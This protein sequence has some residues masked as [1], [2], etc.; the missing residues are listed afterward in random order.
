ML[1]VCLLR[2]GSFNADS[3]LVDR[4]FRKL[5]YDEAGCS[6]NHLLHFA[7]LTV[8]ICRTQ[9]P[10]GLRLNER[11][12]RDISLTQV[13]DSQTIR[14]FGPFD[15]DILRIILHYTSQIWH[16]SFEPFQINHGLVKF[17]P[18][19]ATWVVLVLTKSNRYI[20]F[21]LAIGEAR[22]CSLSIGRVGPGYEKEKH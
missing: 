16:R 1:F 20:L 11:N 22:V 3:C 18:P 8:R 13:K 14:L 12:A 9:S 2:F 7:G 10:R 15:S 19:E 4:R 6:Q 21:M 17:F 5:R